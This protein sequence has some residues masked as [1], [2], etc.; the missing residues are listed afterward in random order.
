VRV[1]DPKDPAGGWQAPGAGASPL[2]H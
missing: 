1:A 2:R